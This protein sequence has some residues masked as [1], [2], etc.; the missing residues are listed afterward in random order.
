MKNIILKKENILIKKG[1]LFL[2]NKYFGKIK[3]PND[4]ILN[5]NNNII[6]LLSLSYKKQNEISFLKIIKNLL[7]GISNLWQ[8]TVFFSGIGYKIYIKKNEIYLNLGFSNSKILIIPNYIIIEVSKEKIILKSVYKDKM[9]IFVNK[10]LKIKKFNP[11]KKK[12]I[13]LEKPI[14]KKSS[15]KKQ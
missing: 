1:F 10:L 13:F 4:I 6:Y 14:L 2:K 3:I 8:K 15:K 9:G 11:Y 7:I 5:V 12:G